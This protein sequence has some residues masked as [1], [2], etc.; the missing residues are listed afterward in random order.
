M[1]NDSLAGAKKKTDLPTEHKDSVRDAAETVVFVVVLVLML[2]LF[3]AEAYVIPTGSMAETQFGHHKNV[4]C[5]ECGYAFRV[6]CSDEV[7]PQVGGRVEVTGYHCPNC[8]KVVPQAD[9]DKG[10]ISDARSGD[11]VLV[12]KFLDHSVHRWDIPVFKFVDSINTRQV[13]NYIKRLIGLP[14][15][16]IGILQGD[17]YVHPNLT[18]P[19]DALSDDGFQSPLYPRPLYAKDLWQLEYT[20]PHAPIARQAFE[21]GE[22]QILR[23]PPDKIL[24]MRRIVYDN[25]F[26]AKSL[27]GKLRPRWFPSGST[28]WQTQQQPNG[29]TLDDVRAPR[30][31]RA[32][33]NELVWLDYQHLVPVW[34]ALEET[35]PTLIRNFTG[36]NMAEETPRRNNPDDAREWVADLMLECEVEIENLDCEILLDL[37]RGPDRFQARF[38]PQ[39]GTCELI[40]T[41][42]SDQPFA[43]TTEAIRKP[44]KYRLRFANFDEKLTVWVDRKVLP[45]GSEAEYTPPQLPR[46][47]VGEI[48]L[49]PHQIMP[50][51]E[52]DEDRPARIGLRGAVTVRKIQLWR[53]TYYLNQQGVLD[54]YYVQPG[55]YLC[56]GDNSAKSY[57]G[58]SWGTVPQ[59]LMLGRALLVYFP[60]GRI[61]VI[62]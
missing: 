27:A 44:G 51:K 47:A 37:A 58:R 42:V 3:V 8:R 24:A 11:R 56:L 13:Q 31:F 5:R 36:Y 55:H 50:V 23:K 9:R 28:S 60:L 49:L 29:W 10:E 52:N 54:T 46:P 20:Y 26:Q 57:D 35:K 53:D 41:A 62:E 33:G 59:R 22:F 17:L 21:K 43:T 15:E 38:R 12:A 45:F 18:Y 4:V 1:S 30:S 14:G 7:E 61:G 48:P 39:A 2:K 40:R 16:T 25:D 6:N 32:T 19:E 34:S